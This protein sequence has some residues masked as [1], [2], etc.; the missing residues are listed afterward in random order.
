MHIP[1]GILTIPVWAAL[2]AVAAPCVGLAVRRAKRGL[3]EGQ[4]PL[5]GVVGAFVFAAQRMNFPVGFGTSG[6]LL[7][8]ALLAM[9]L[10]PGAAT[11]VLTAILIL[12]ALLFQD[13]GLLALGSNVMNMAVLGVWAGWLP[14]RMLSAGGWRTAGV[15]MGGLLSVMASAAAAVLELRLSGAAMSTAVVG[16]SS[17]VFLVTGVMEGLITVAVVQA[18]ERLNPG[19]M[20]KPAGVPS[21]SAGLLVTLALV[22]MVGGVLYISALPDGLQA[23][24]AGVGM[25]AKEEH[26]WAAPL[27]DYE[28]PMVA[29]EWGRKSLAGLAGVAII[30]GVCLTVGRFLVRQRSA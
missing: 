25:G 9:T 30:Y 21:R 19:W 2:N 7:G 1:D 20:R 6:H 3:A 27:A 28:L 29:G 5:L 13:G 4:A 15:F 14:Y 10:G 18:V 26:W 23:L 8:G 22:M 24:A 11:I 17:A 12:Q 16:V